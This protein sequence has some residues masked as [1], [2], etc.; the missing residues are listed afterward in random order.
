MGYVNKT[1]DGTS[2]GSIDNVV[3]S[4]ELGA[5]DSSSYSFTYDASYSKPNSSAVVELYYST[6]SDGS[7]FNN[8]SWTLAESFTEATM[9]ADRNAFD[10]RTVT[11]PVSGKF[12]VAIRITA[13][14]G[15][16]NTSNDGTRWRYDNIRIS[17]E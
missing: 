16:A 8:G 6:D 2:S 9:G 5:D 12:H 4:P 11:I 14:I 15:D 1:T 3:I 7:S 13:E 17:D 10:R